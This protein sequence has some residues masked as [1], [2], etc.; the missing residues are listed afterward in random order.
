MLN[1]H[2]HPSQPDPPAIAITAEATRPRPDILYLRYHLTGDLAALR[3]PPP[4]TPTRRDELWRRT[5]FEA[6][7]RAANDPAYVEFNLSP[8]TEWAAYAFS[9][10]RAGMRPVAAQPAIEVERA[11]EILTLRAEIMIPDLPPNCSWR[12]ALSAVIEDRIGRATHWTLH[13]P[14]PAPDFHHPNGFVLDLPGSA[15]HPAGNLA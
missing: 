13:H 3:I 2:P 6:F 5:C 11:G 9:D 1:L 8:S 14:A 12:V 7:A 4:S 15:F 10:T